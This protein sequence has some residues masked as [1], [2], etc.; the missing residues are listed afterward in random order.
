[1]AFSKSGLIK[2]DFE[3]FSKSDFI[4]PEA[5]SKSDFIRPDNR[6]LFALHELKAPYTRSVR[7]YTLVA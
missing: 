4:R 3:A 6:L 2:S 1:L 7:P 5:F